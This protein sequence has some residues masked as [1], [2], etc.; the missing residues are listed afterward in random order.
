MMPMST[1]P[2]TA[3]FSSSMTATATAPPTIGLPEPE[4]VSTPAADSANGP[5]MSPA[6]HCVSPPVPA[7]A[8]PASPHLV[9][10]TAPEAIPVPTREIAV[11]TDGLTRS[12]NGI[13]AVDG[14]NLRVPTG[15]IYGL[16]GPSGAGKSIILKLLVGLTRPTSGRMSILGHPVSPR[17]P[18]PP[19][20]IGSLIE[21]PSYYPGLTGRENLTMMASYLGL[22]SSRVTYVLAGV[23]LSGHENKR[24][25]HYSTGM[26]QRLGLA[27]ALL[28]DPPL[29]VLDEPTNGLD[30]AE[31]AE[32]RGLIV[33]LARQ[34][35]K[36]IIVSSR[37]LSEIGQMADTVGVI[38]AGRLRYQGPL[39][40]LHDDGVIEMT[41][42]APTAVS[43]LLT[44]LGVPH[45]VHDAVVRTA[46]MSD[47]AIGELI[48]SIVTSGTTVYRVQTVRR[49][50]EEAFLELTDPPSPVTQPLT[51]T[52]EAWPP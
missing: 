38:R 29:I 40:G 11:T 32:I 30:P 42:S 41:V 20:A 49:T 25:K 16:L 8:S 31:A 10:L 35:G 6:D 46:M 26:R 3:S 22:P 47:N 45:E 19:G 17:H 21:G 23:D 48:T 36:T 18:P 24:V 28:A 39:S 50:L 51:A 33:T 13:N 9:A 27:M 37:F 44:S 2:P 1:A 5:V 4:I 34:E 52:R 12:Y 15:G 7:A 14:V 43:T